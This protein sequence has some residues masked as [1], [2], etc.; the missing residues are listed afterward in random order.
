M[1]RKNRIPN[2]NENSMCRPVRSDFNIGLETKS[3][4]PAPIFNLILNMESLTKSLVSLSFLFLV[5]V[6]ISRKVINNILT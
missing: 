6:E 2:Y 3:P 1:Y 4:P 5:Q